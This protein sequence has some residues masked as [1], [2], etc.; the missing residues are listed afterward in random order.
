MDNLV[1]DNKQANDLYL[2]TKSE[3][4]YL[5]SYLKRK[6][7]EDPYRSIVSRTLYQAI[8]GASAQVPTFEPWK[9]DV[10]VVS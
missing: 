1:S 5:I 10:D 6:R 2:H 8:W 3:V 4:E 9:L 7:E